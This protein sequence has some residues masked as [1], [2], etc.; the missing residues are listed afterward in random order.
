[1]ISNPLTQPE[2]NCTQPYC[3]ISRAADVVTYYASGAH[4]SPWKVSHNHSV[5]SGDIVVHSPC[6]DETNT[7]SQAILDSE[8]IAFA[9]PLLLL[10]LAQVLL[11]RAETHRLH[12]C[13][14]CNTKMVD[15]PSLVLSDMIL[16]LP[17]K[18]RESTKD[19]E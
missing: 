1:M 2:Q 18:L 11:E 10:G 7:P 14:Y 9:Q 15:C 13:Y 19:V 4:Q 5:V 16:E 6:E 3:R 12:E 8:Y 17:Q